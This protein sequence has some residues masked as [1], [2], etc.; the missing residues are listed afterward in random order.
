MAGFYTAS[1]MTDNDDYEFHF[2]RHEQT[3]LRAKIHSRFSSTTKH[4]VFLE[5]QTVMNPEALQVI[6]ALARTETETRDVVA[7]LHL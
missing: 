2:H 4:D 6:T 7:T 1:H 5:F 3:L